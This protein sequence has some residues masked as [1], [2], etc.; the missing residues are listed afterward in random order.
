MGIM[1]MVLHVF[2]SGRVYR[3]VKS[4]MQAIIPMTCSAFATTGTGVMVPTSAPRVPHAQMKLHPS[5]H[6]VDAQGHLT[7]NALAMAVTGTT[8]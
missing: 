6:V 1:A 7:A 4:V 2:R 3:T 5:V 8:G